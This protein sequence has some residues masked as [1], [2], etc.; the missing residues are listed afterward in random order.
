M[1]ENQNKSVAKDKQTLKLFGF[2]PLLSI[3]RRGGKTAY[4]FLGMPIWKIRRMENEKLIKCYLFNFPILRFY[5]TPKQSAAEIMF[6]QLQSELQNIVLK[7]NK[8]QDEL[9]STGDKIEQT[10]Q[11][12]MN[13]VK[14]NEDKIIQ[15]RQNLIDEVKLSVTSA[16]KAQ[17]T[18]TDTI[19]EALRQ[20]NE[21]Y[22]QSARQIRNNAEQMQN[23]EDRVR[24]YHAEV[25]ER[26]DS[27]PV[28]H[29]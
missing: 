10:Q 7:H 5:Y 19:T 23:I 26:L 18:I 4:Y 14:L 20:L 6:E 9:Q 25:L 11:N 2:I 13:A 22:N 15:T 8:L 17:Q 27:L 21:N 12:I 24:V 29:E 3:K 16:E 28:K 1:I